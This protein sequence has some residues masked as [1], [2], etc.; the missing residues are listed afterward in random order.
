M[1]KMWEGKGKMVKDNKEAEGYFSNQAAEY[2]NMHYQNINSK[3]RYPSLYLRHQYVLKMLK[4]LKGKALDIG[5]GSGVMARDML[6]MGFDVTA[7]DISSAML[8]ATKKTV[9]NVPRKD[10]LVT[11]VQDIENLSFPN[12]HFDVIVCLGVI[13]YT[14]DD[15]KALAEIARV[16]KPNGTAIISSQN[17]I[18][19]MRMI[20][21]IGYDVLP[22]SIRKKFY[23]FQQ[24]K[25]HTPWTLDKDAEAVRLVKE[26]T[27]Y[28]H[29]YPLPIPLDRVFPKFCVKHGM[30]MEKMSSKKHGWM[31]ATGFVTRY[32]KR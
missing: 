12:D 29:F 13:E 24:H 18:C 16:L 22:K 4:G 28:H 15:K 25:C 8:T 2:Y 17:K 1:L 6:Y 32:Y 14:H 26:Y 7:A 30:K 21:E 3:S 5:C 19:P 23:T 10:S 27:S 9:E 11:S 31:F 20:E